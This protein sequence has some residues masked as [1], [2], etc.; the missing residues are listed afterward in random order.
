[1]RTRLEELD[2]PV[3]EGLESKPEGARS[4]WRE[5]ALS[6]ATGANSTAALFC[7]SRLNEYEGSCFFGF[8]SEWRF[9]TNEQFS[10]RSQIFAATLGSSPNLPTE[11]SESTYGVATFM[12]EVQVSGFLS[13]D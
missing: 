8:S 4:I 11:A 13:V 9:T 6:E 12:T 7:I 10:A 3:V 5:V 2:A 1:M